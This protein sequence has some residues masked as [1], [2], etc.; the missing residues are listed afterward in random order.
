MKKSV[1]LNFIYVAVFVILFSS[2]ASSTLIQSSPPGARV[3][4]N[5]QLAGKTPFLYSDTK[6][7]GSI[8]DIDLVKEGYEPLYTSIERN[9]QVD[10]GAVIG[11]FMFG[12]P[13]LWTLEY[14]PMHYYELEPIEQEVEGKNSRMYNES[15]ILNSLSQGSD[16]IST[17]ADRLRELK[18]L[19]DEKLIT[20]EDFEKQKQIILNQI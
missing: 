4:I 8:T 5:G 6:I 16:E 15:P 9:E 2:C 19:L 3:Y 1:K 18:Y 20:N 7:L 12:V 11:G 17:K 10:L 14:N 13:F